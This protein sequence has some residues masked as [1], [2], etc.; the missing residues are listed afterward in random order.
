MDSFFEEYCPV[1]IG[2][3][4]GSG[5]RLISDLCTDLGIYMGADL[6]ESSDTMYFVDFYDKWINKWYEFRNRPFSISS[7]R[8]DFRN[9]FDKYLM[10]RNSDRIGWKNPRSIH[11]L[12]FF[13]GL[14][15]KMK[16]IHVVRDG[17]DVAFSKTQ[18]QVERHGY[19]ILGETAVKVNKAV[20]SALVWN[21]CN[22]WAREYCEMNLVK[23]Y[24]IIKYE[25]ICKDARNEFERVSKFVG[26]RARKN[27]IEAHAC[28]VED[29]LQKKSTIGR[30][31][32][33]DPYTLSI[34]Q[35]E[36][37]DGLREYGYIQ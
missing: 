9:S 30:Y 18:I 36:I 26:V 31:Q 19:A 20:A 32:S 29:F 7:M 21:T 24:L 22:R 2:G 5:T 13:H 15:P 33:E 12:D 23:S 34:I 28:G 25:D 17:R 35:A 37:G 3:I 11:L 8:D 1:I 4:G 27:V 6:N 16:F 14:F 10:E